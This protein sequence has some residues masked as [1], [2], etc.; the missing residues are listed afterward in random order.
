M[1]QKQEQWGVYRLSLTEA[2]YEVNFLDVNRDHVNEI[3]ENGFF[4]SGKGRQKVHKINISNNEND[5]KNSTDI[6]LFHA[7]TT[8]TKS[9]SRAVAAVLKL[10]VT[11]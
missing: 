1:W 10:M 7:D 5:F 9:A 6:V 11:L 2:G 3:K 4:L 8:G